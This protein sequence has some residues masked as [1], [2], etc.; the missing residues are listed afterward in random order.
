MDGLPNKKFPDYFKNFELPKEFDTDEFVVYRA[1]KTCNVDRESFLN[2]YEE[3]GYMVSDTHKNNPS[4]YS[5]S[6][7]SNP[8]DVLRFTRIDRRFHQ[9]SDNKFPRPWKAAQGM[10]SSECGPHKRSSSYV[11]KDGRPKKTSHVDWWLYKSAKPWL[12]FTIIDN[13]NDYIKQYKKEAE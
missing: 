8:K 5:M 12:N 13:L 2:S 10:T 9:S 6:V 7:Y 3:A 1:C 11:G 4:T